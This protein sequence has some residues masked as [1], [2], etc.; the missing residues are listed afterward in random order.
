MGLFLARGYALAEKAE[1]ADVILVNTCSVRGHAEHRAISY[2]G[3]LKKLKGIGPSTSLR[4]NNSKNIVLGIIGCMAVNRGEE[5]FKKM[6][7]INLVCG[8]ASFDKI[9]GYIERIKEEGIKIKDIK[10]RERGEELYRACFR[11]DS[12]HAQVVIS[13]GCSNYCT[14]CVVPYVRGELRLRSPED[15]IGEVER[16]VK[17]GIKKITLLGQNVNDYIYKPQSHTLMGTGKATSKIRNTQYAM[18][19]TKINFVDLLRMI[20]E[21]EG[22]REINFISSQPKNISKE[23][24][25]LMAKS[26]KIE[27]HLHLPFQSGSDRIL[28]LMNRGYTRQKY[29]GLVDDYKKIVGNSLS[30]DVIVGFPTETNEDFLQTKDIL[31][32]VNF[33][34]AYIFKYSPRLR[35][36]SAEL[37]DDVSGEIKAKRHKILLDLQKKISLKKIRNPNIEIRNKF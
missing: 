37:T 15:I 24:F 19:N 32:R 26:S 1:E 5:I 12:N 33:S 34:C 21:I 9:P 14:Y 36:K 10:D 29:L 27:K 31:E 3:S 30:T 28:K 6:L 2:L 16:N 23:L 13:T 4:I 17:L 35:A 11:E 22:L 7:H 8:P 20:D 18:R 25:T